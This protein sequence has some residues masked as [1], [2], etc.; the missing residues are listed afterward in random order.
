MTFLK[1]KESGEWYESHMCANRHMMTTDVD[2][3]G[4]RVAAAF[5]AENVVEPERR[6]YLIG[7]RCWIANYPFKLGMRE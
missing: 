4:V 1:D 3:L 5:F 6:E 2:E 7:W